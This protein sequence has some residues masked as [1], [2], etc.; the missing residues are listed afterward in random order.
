MIPKEVQKVMTKAEVKQVKNVYPVYQKSRYTDLWQVYESASSGK[1][2]AWE[3]CKKLCYSQ[4]GIG[5]KIISYN[6]YTFTAGFVF[7]EDGVNKFMYITP[8]RD[9][10]VEID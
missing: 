10:A 1:R 4:Q 6:T 8:S 3:Y 2:N 5:L 9:I 7:E